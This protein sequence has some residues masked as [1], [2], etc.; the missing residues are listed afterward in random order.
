MTQK[1]TTHPDVAGHAGRTA[2][3][4]SRVRI[5]RPGTYAEVIETVLC[6]ALNS[7]G[8]FVQCGDHCERID[9]SRSRQNRR[10]AEPSHAAAAFFRSNVVE[11]R[12]LE[13][14]RADPRK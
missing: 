14:P 4:R 11:L 6:D 5:D 8:N 10:P 2:V 7:M 9:Q 1:L 3:H 12:G 13:I